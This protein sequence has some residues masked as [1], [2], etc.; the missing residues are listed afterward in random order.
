[1]WP[2]QNLLQLTF[3]LDWKSLHRY[4]AIILFFVNVSFLVGTAGWLAQL[5]PGTRRDIVCR[6]D[7]TV[8]RA[9]PQ[10]GYVFCSIREM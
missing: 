8:R 1:M 7:G 5:I 2:V 3:I 4:P 6:N 9:E 10:I